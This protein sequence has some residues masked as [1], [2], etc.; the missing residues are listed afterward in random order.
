LDSSASTSVK[1][2]LWGYCLSGIEISVAGFDQSTNASCSQPQV[3]YTFD[4][5]VSEALDVTGLDDLISRVTT[6][7]LVIHPISAALSFLA[8]LTTLFLLIRTRRKHG[9]PSRLISLVFVLLAAVLTTI[10]FLIDAIF[11]GK[12]RSRLADASEDTLT[13]SWGN[14]VW[15][16][17]VAALSLWFAMIMRFIALRRLSRAERY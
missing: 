16:T 13:L 2:G 6:A 12:V 5:T 3:G 14:A 10:V 8:F 17:L 11:V 9:R 4:D 7:A 1:F 15:L